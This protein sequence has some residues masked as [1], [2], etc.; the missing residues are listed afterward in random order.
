MLRKAPDPSGLQLEAKGE[1]KQSKYVRFLVLVQENHRD[2]SRAISISIERVI[3]RV[4]SQEHRNLA[5]SP[6]AVSVFF[7]PM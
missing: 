2:S 4:L 5:P 7:Y 1:K 3:T 6:V